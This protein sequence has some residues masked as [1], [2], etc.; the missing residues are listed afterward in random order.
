M[1]GATPA[2]IAVLVRRAGTAVIRYRSGSGSVGDAN[3]GVG[4]CSSCGVFWL[5]NSSRKLQRVRVPDWLS[6]ARVLRD[7]Q[8]GVG[9]GVVG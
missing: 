8:S 2:L 3:V 9:G 4:L 5:L 7:T 1:P 6:N